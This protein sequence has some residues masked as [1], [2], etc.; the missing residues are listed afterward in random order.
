MVVPAFGFSAGDF[1]AAVGVLK[2]TAR[3]LRDSG[4]A[5]SQYQHAVL[6]LRSLRSAL[7]RLQS[8]EPASEDVSIVEEIRKCSKTCIIA[9]DK[10]LV[11]IEKLDRDLEYK[12]RKWRKAHAQVKWAM[13]LEPELRQLEASLDADVQPLQI[14]L[15]LDGRDSRLESEKVTLETRDL[16]RHMS[17][18]FENSV[19]LFSDL[20]VP[21]AAQL[22]KLSSDLPEFGDEFSTTM[23]R[24]Q[25]S[26]KNLQ[27]NQEDFEQALSCSISSTTRHGDSSS[28][29]IQFQG[30]KH[31]LE[32]RLVIYG[33]KL[34]QIDAA[35]LYLTLD[36]L[37]EQ[38]IRLAL[39]LICLMPTVQHLLSRSSWN[40]IRAPTWLLDNNIRLEDC[41]G[42][43]MSLPFEHFRHWNLVH[44]KLEIVLKGTP[45]ERKLRENQFAIFGFGSSLHESN[46]DAMIYPGA[47]ATMSIPFDDETVDGICPSCNSPGLTLCKQEWRC[48]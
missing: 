25:G 23:H 35:L 41:L 37:A 26:M 34:G 29:T 14:L 21:M 12:G 28:K 10:F 3:A 7:I 1:I 30:N 33:Q 36:A 38:S 4:G 22:D 31:S 39:I 19:A 2:K 15:Q 45:G 18:V 24:I 44:A 16:V 32:S 42:R 5:A 9:L 13:R 43:S 11:T 46:W 47:S 48:W 17:N 20:A 27:R 40:L 6:K 8:L